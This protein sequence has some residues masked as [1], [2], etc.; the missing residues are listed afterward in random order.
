[1]AVDGPRVSDVSVHSEIA[2]GQSHYRQDRGRPKPPR[3]IGPAEDQGQ[4]AADQAGQPEN[5]GH[6]GERNFRA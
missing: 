6:R 4:P 3:A 5:G 2:D 1:M